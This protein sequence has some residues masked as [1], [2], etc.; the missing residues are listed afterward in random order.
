MGLSR[1][2]DR[3]GSGAAGVPFR[4]AEIQERE[5]RLLL[6][7]GVSLG[8]ERELRVRVSRL[9]R[10]PT[11]ASARLAGTGRLHDWRQSTLRSS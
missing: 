7:E 8:S 6:A 10:D 11:V 5:V 3:A 2:S 4:A 9:S 1:S